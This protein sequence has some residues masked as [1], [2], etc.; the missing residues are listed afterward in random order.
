MKTK[1][2]DND[3]EIND[4]EAVE[5]LAVKVR[6]RS[7]EDIV[8]NEHAL[9]VISGYFNRRQIVKT[10]LL[11][12][13]TGS[14]KCVTGD[15]LVPTI[16]GLIPIKEIV[17]DID[18]F[19]EKNIKVLTKNGV[20]TTSHVFS[21]KSK[22]IK[23][24]TDYGYGLEGTP[25]HPVYVLCKDLKHRWKKLSKIKKGDFICIERDK[26]LFS[27]SKY[28]VDFTHLHSNHDNNSTEISFPKRVNRK[29]ARFLGYLVAN[30]G[31]TNGLSFST[32]NIVIQKDYCKLVYK[33]FRIKTKFTSFKG[34]VETSII[35]SVQLIGLLEN[36]GLKFAGSRYKE[37]P[38]SILRSPKN[39]I[40]EYLSGYF[41]CDSYIPSKGDIELCT[42][43]KKM[44]NQ[45]HILLTN[46]GIISK[47]VRYKSYA[48]NSNTP[49]ERMYSSI[50]IKNNNKDIFFDTFKIRKEYIR[51]KWQDKDGIPHIYQAL[52]SS[53]K[54]IEHGSG[55]YGVDYTD[56]ISIKFPIVKKPGVFRCNTLNKIPYNYIE[57]IN[58]HGLDLVLPNMSNKIRTIFKHRFFYD[59]VIN[60][61]KV[62]KRKKVY[63]LT[64]P[65]GA[66]FIGNGIVIHNTTLARL[67]GTI[68]NCENLKGI[69]PCLKCQSCKMT[70]SGSHPD[71]IE[72]NAAGEAGKIDN[73]RNTLNLTKYAP[74]FN[75]KCIICDEI[76]D[77]SPK[78]KVELLKPLEEP[79]PKTIWIL[80]TTAPEKLPKATFGR[81][82]KLYLEY[83]TVNA[84]AKRL[85]V[86]AK[87]EYGV[88]VSKSVK[89]YLKTVVD[90]CGCQPRNSI[91]TLEQ[92]VAVIHSEKDKTLS[93]KEVKRVIS[94]VLSSSGELSPQVIKFLAH[95]Y[96]KKKLTPFKIMSEIDSTKVE[97]FISLCY[98]YSFYAVSYYLMKKVGKKPD[99]QKFWGINFI[100]WENVINKLESDITDK[101]PLKMCSAAI[102]ATEKSRSGII[103][104]EQALLFM[105]QRFLT[106]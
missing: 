96:T 23:I 65:K 92:I 49:I 17:G 104:P 75:M 95:I 87:K 58:F 9:S 93:K 30:G 61:K 83:P 6:P 98:R 5:A 88:K 76:Q 10:W 69:T 71:I 62:N 12:G 3:E 86:I 78:S 100:R 40:I 44:G 50:F 28:N 101:I 54:D 19:E 15:T 63:D 48:R 60:I 80:C 70:L 41:S 68:V 11:S 32:N 82:L 90:G 34:K 14:G 27:N 84:M 7:L 52:Y 13:Q 36:I 20:K 24:E 105:V 103:N 33:L 39:I 38:F 2:K 46:F 91:S 25:E 47:K 97:E 89:P 22:T 85:Y 66:N 53:L 94:N 72:I 35:S 16:N 43:S 45:L 73:I 51:S 64:I 74:R 57:H 1:K 29:L 21:K 8:G 42:A 99:K 55:T 79:P 18:G 59:K 106:K 56:D 81:C 31:L 26:F 4:M 67:I 102:E 37:I 77:A